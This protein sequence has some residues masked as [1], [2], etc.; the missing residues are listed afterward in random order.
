MTR[1]PSLLWPPWNWLRACF[2]R[3]CMCHAHRCCARR[4][5]GGGVSMRPELNASVFLRRTGAFPSH[6]LLVTRSP[7]LLVT[8]SSRLGMESKSCGEARVS[9]RGLDENRKQQKTQQKHTRHNTHTQHAPLPPSPPPGPP[10]PPPPPPWSWQRFAMTMANFA[11]S[12]ANFAMPM[13]NF[14]MTMAN[15]FRFARS[16]EACS[17]VG[18]AERGTWLLAMMFLA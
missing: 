8:R 2:R 18:L 5:T 15:C 9:A 11:M 16:A 4:A 17:G 14:G 13:A 1:S 3:G 6:G 12:M 10:G 7:R